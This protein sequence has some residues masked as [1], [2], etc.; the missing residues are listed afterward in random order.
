MLYRRRSLRG[1]SVG[2]AFS[3]GVGTLFASAAFYFYMPIS[4]HSALLP[5]LY[6][7]TLI[8]DLIYVGMVVMLKRDIVPPGFQMIDMPVEQTSSEQ[9]VAS[10]TSH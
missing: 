6:L 9:G 4:Q 8:Y 7:A 10:S 2:I 5:F 3:K 1:Q